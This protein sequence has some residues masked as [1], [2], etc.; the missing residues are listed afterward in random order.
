MTSISKYIIIIAIIL[1]TLEYIIVGPQSI[2]PVTGQASPPLHHPSSNVIFRFLPSPLKPYRKRRPFS[3]AW[4]IQVSNRFVSG[5]TLAGIRN[6]S[7]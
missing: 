4:N 1:Y 2:Y 6:Q 7:E 5:V 3:C